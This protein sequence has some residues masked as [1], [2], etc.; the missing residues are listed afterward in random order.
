MIPL[1]DKVID[2]LLKRKNVCDGMVFGQ[3]SSGICLF[4]VGL[5]KIDGVSLLCMEKKVF[6]NR[7]IYLSSN[8]GWIKYYDAELL[9]SLGTSSIYNDYAWFRNFEDF[10]DLAKKH[11]KE[12]VLKARYGK[13]R[14][15]NLNDF[16]EKFA[17]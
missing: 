11:F 9:A 14:L 2:R 8:D 5:F 7:S 17:Q 12:N 15:G 4:R 13:M 1:K 16:S 3:V 10:Q 6:D